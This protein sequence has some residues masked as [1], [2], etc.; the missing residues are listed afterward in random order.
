MRS[1]RAALGSFS[2]N[3]SVAEAAVTAKFKFPLPTGHIRGKGWLH[4][5]SPKSPSKEAPTFLLGKEKATNPFFFL[6]G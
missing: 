6:S 2:L 3:F 5:N 4:L 1:K